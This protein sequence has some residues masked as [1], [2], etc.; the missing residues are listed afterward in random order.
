MRISIAHFKRTL[1]Q[2][3]A[4]KN[5]KQAD[6]LA[7]HLLSK[8][9]KSFWNEVKS[10]NQK[11]SPAS[12]VAGARG[13]EAISAMWQRHYQGLLNSLTDRSKTDSVLR[14]LHS[15]IDSDTMDRITPDDIK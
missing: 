3:K 5:R 9:C 12:T 8:D 15:L 10:H 7:K 13:S 14:V 6:S 2:C 11:V 4:D 1:H